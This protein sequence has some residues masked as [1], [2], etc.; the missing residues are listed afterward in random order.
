MARRNRSF[1]F[2]NKTGKLQSDGKTLIDTTSSDNIAQVKGSTAGNPVQLIADG[3][4]TNID[5]R[6]TPKGAGNVE[7]LGTLEILTGKRI[8]D[9]A[10]TNV[11]FG[12]DIHMNS[13]KIT[14]LG[15]PSASTDAATK[16]Y[17]D[18]NYL[19]LTGGTI[20]SNLTV[21]GNFT[22]SGTTTTIN[23]TTLSVAD[24]LID[25]NSDVTSGTPTENAGI[26]VLRG[27]SNAVQLRWNE[28]SDVWEMTTDGSTYQTIGSL[29][30]SDTDDLSEGSTNL[31]YT[32]ARVRSAISVTNAGGDGSLTY[33]SST[34]VITYTGPD[35]LALA[36]GTMSGAIAMGTNKITDMGDP[37]AAQDAATKAYV[38]SQVSSVPTGDI[39]SV[40]ASTGLSGGGTTGDVTLSID[41]TVATLTGT[42][43]L[44]NK[45]LTSP[46]ITTDIR[47]NAQAE[48]EFYDSDSSHYVSLRA[49]ATISSSVTWTLPNTDGTEGQVLSTNGAGV[50]SWAD[51][52]SGGGGSGASY[53]NSTFSTVPG[54]DGNFDMSYNVAQTTQ[55]TPFEASGT[56]AFGVNLGSVF[57]LMDPVG[58]LESI[59]YGDSEAY[60]GA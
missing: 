48:L 4:D 28:T 7:V 45:T 16:G 39:T 46:E 43:T 26:R 59:D 32:D 19:P 47:L 24:N 8:I 41:S 35:A 36:G 12:D 25:L 13:N 30:S 11:E 51:A 2:D 50:F 42:Q 33:N 23:T 9:S 31:Y 6:I 49:P 10:G 27:D 56:D 14:N 54:T 20:S 55:E 22:V 57:S 3:D 53:P 38:D 18:T 44:T 37:T 52:G 15:T 21:S 60:V 58:S 29:A 1:F 34:G 17:V 5:I 40:T